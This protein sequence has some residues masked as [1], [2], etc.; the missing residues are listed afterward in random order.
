MGEE[1]N[2]SSSGEEGDGA[3]HWRNNRGRGGREKG[4]GKG[5]GKGEPVQGQTIEARRKD[6]NK[7]LSERW[8]RPC[9]L[10]LGVLSE[11]ALVCLLEIYTLAPLH[12][13]E[14]VQPRMAGW[15]DSF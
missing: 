13:L 6:A 10:L 5:R 2:V 11:P 7:V 3:A 9:R 1:G 14:V 4:K 15:L 12:Q 8:Q